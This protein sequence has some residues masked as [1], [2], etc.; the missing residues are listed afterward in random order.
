MPDGDTAGSNADFELQIASSV[1]TDWWEDALH[2]MNVFK[3]GLL[4]LGVPASEVQ[5]DLERWRTEIGPVVAEAKRAEERARQEREHPTKPEDLHTD[6]ISPADTGA[7]Y[8][9]EA[10]ALKLRETALDRFRAL[11]G[12][13]DYIVVNAERVET[14]VP[15]FLLAAPPV[16]GAKVTYVE[17]VSG[18]WSTSW[19]VTALGAGTGARRSLTAFTSSEFAAVEGDRQL[20]YLPTTYEV[21]EIEVRS[22][23]KT[24]G[25]GPRVQLVAPGETDVVHNTCRPLDAAEQPGEL[26]PDAPREQPWKLAGARPTD[27]PTFT[28]RW[29][30][31][32]ERTLDLG[33]KI[34]RFADLNAVV[35]ICRTREVTLTFALPGGKDY[36]VERLRSR[37]G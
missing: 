18:E 22:H 16:P 32:G 9:Y 29:T 34:P 2:S 11:I 20:I 37:K 3:S 35:K 10:E 27:L 25:R 28:E 7:R 4:E 13:R 23:G 15:L 6:A 17:S 12:L 8:F 36:R 19:S 5:A 26:D 30:A 21:A 33:L 1:K 31:S 24:I 14:E